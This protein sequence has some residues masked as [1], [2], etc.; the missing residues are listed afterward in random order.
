MNNK[1]RE[2]IVDTIRKS[3]FFKQCAYK[4]TWISGSSTVVH[5]LTM[6]PADFIHEIDIDIH[7]DWRKSKGRYGKFR[8]LLNT[9]RRRFP[10]L[11]GRYVKLD[12]SCPDFYEIWKAK[13]RPTHELP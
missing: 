10:K 9:L 8:K 13:A 4:G 3:A 6:W 1:D 2:W 5:P 7:L 12:G 11:K